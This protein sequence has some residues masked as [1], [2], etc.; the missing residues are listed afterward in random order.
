M[1][2]LSYQTGSCSKGDLTPR[3]GNAL[4]FFQKISRLELSHW[5]AAPN[6]IK[7]LCCSR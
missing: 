2:C 7:A 5:D 4:D 1:H 3:A 6:A